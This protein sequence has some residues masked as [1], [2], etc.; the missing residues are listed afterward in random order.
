[1]EKEGCGLFYD[2]LCHSLCVRIPPT[3]GL[4]VSTYETLNGTYKP[5]RIITMPE[6]PGITISNT[7]LELLAP[8]FFIPRCKL[9]TYQRLY[10][11]CDNSWLGDPPH[12]FFFLHFSLHIRW[13]PCHHSMARPRVVDGGT[14]SSYGGQMRI[15]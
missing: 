6:T 4:P 5:D 3:I 2:L 10:A 11:L 12:L 13:Y 14:V 15:Q 1:M 8:V 7:W 9:Q